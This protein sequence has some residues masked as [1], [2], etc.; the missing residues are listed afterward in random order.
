VDLTIPLIR[1]EDIPL[2]PHTSVAITRRQKC[3]V[4]VS[5]LLS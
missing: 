3:F 1:R 4:P 5:A 2:L